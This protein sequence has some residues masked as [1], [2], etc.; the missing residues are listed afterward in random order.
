MTVTAISGDHFTCSGTGS[1]TVETRAGRR[2]EI[3]VWVV[4][5]PPMIGGDLIIGMAG[6][7]ALGGVAVVGQ[8]EVQFCGARIDRHRT[9]TLQISM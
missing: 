6:I 5:D 3:P 1:V 9:W 4:S 2:V 8:S 7:T